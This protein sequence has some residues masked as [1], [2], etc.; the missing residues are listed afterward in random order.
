MDLVRRLQLFSLLFPVEKHLTWTGAPDPNGLIVSPVA[1]FAPFLREL[2][3]GILPI[4]RY[5]TDGAGSIRTLVAAATL[6]DVLSYQVPSAVLLQE[7]HAIREA[8]YEIAD[9]I[10]DSPQCHTDIWKSVFPTTK[11]PHPFQVLHKRIENL[12]HEGL[13]DPAE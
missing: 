7:S 13:I 1:L 4:L 5:A 12:E 6:F 9:M 2:M 11:G 10:R 8:L 3:A